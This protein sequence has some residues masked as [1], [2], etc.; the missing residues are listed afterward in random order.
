MA[1]FCY[2]ICGRP[3]II[4]ICTKCTKHLH[5]YNEKTTFAC[6]LLELLKYCRVRPL[7]LVFLLA[8]LSNTKIIWISNIHNLIFSRGCKIQSTWKIYINICMCVYCKICF[9]LNAFLTKKNLQY[10]ALYWW[11]Y[12]RITEQG[13]SG[14]K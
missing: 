7:I 3:L 5:M 1:F 8:G 9:Y 4:S 11:M 10:S 2:I 14:K 12:K 6:L 13:H